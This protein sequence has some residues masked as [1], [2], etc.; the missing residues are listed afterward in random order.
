VI[1]PALIA[2]AMAVP[3]SDVP[4]VE[5][6]GIYSGFAKARL[7]H[8]P[9][10]VGPLPDFPDQPWYDGPVR[11]QGV[12]DSWNTAAG[13]E[14]F[15]AVPDDSTADITFDTRAQEHCPG[16]G[17][18]TW[19]HQFSTGWYRHVTVSLWPWP[20]TDDLLAHE[21]GHGLGFRDVTDPHA[22]YDGIM[23]YGRT[24]HFDPD[25]EYDRASLV[26]AGYREAP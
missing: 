2:L 16:Y 18:C 8:Q 5:L 4:T 19:A 6:I 25:N 7:E 14:L 23:S 12:L 11:L 15:V 24:E 26:E 21:L 1:A 3:A 10:T 9:I 22:P 13:W 20:A 17:A